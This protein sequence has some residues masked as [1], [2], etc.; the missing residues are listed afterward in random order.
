LFDSFCA[1]LGVAV[2]GLGMMKYNF[3][4]S[5]ISV[6]ISIAL[7]YVF[8]HKY[9]VMG[10]AIAQALSYFITFIIVYFMAWHVFGIYFKK[11]EQ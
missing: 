7:S 9:G 10:A 3:Y 8:I 4:S 2:L 5:L 6:P 1:L 11:M